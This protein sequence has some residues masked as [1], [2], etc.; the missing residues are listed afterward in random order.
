MKPPSLPD[1]ERRRGLSPNAARA[2]FRAGL[3]TP[4]AG[5]CAG[6]TQANL[7]AVPSDLAYDML[8]FAHRNPKACPSST[9]VTRARCPRP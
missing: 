4:T 6:W 1:A 8:L 3:R 2:V 7:I 9:S 5:W